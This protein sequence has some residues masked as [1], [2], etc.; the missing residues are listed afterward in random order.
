[1]EFE[2]LEL[3]TAALHKRPSHGPS[4]RNVISC[5]ILFGTACSS[6]RVNLLLIYLIKVLKN[7]LIQYCCVS[8]Y[9]VFKTVPQMHKLLFLSTLALDKWSHLGPPDS[10]ARNANHVFKH[11]SAAETCDPM[12]PRCARTVTVAVAAF[13]SSTLRGLAHRFKQ[14]RHWPS[15]QFWRCQSHE[16]L[17]RRQDPIGPRRHQRS[18]ASPLGRARERA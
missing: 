3:R 2:S 7:T 1:M 17:R 15:P 9:S 10:I 18:L 8:S 5:T 6:I 11:R 16:Y 13:I 12:K 14:R 4:D